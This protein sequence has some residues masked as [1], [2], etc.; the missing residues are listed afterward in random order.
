MLKSLDL[1]YVPPEDGTDL[2]KHVAAVK[3]YTFKCVFFL[4]IVLVLL[5]N[6]NQNA[7]N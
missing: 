2:P 6:I 4:Y 3:D 5:M 7:C 1:V